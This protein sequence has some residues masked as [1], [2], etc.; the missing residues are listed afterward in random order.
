MDLITA[1]STDQSQY[2]TAKG[3]AAGGT[4]FGLSVTLKFAYDPWKVLLIE[5]TRDVAVSLVAEVEDRK[6]TWTAYW[7]DQTTSSADLF[8]QAPGTAARFFNLGL[9]Q[10]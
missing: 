7:D 9:E 6:P 2:D 1:V 5:C 10:P 4:L 8:A 3:L